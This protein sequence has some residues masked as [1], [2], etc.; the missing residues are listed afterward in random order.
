MCHPLVITRAIANRLLLHP[1]NNLIPPSANLDPNYSLICLPPFGMFSWRPSESD[2]QG[3]KRRERGE[4]RLAPSQAQRAN[5]TFLSR[6]GQQQRQRRRRPY[7]LIG[8]RCVESRQ[9]SP[10]NIRPTDPQRIV[11]LKNKAR[12]L[13][14][15]GDNWRP[16]RELCKLDSFRRSLFDIHGERRTMD[17]IRTTTIE[18]VRS[19][20]MPAL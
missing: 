6:K 12:P 9:P 15:E 2:R 3:A 4:G 17:N 10:G 18:R 14:K 19:D 16:T 8:I 7:I 11:S 13:A 1:R 20:S 5:L